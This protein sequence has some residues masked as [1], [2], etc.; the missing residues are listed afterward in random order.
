MAGIRYEFESTLFPWAARRELW[1]FARLPHDVSA[2]IHDAPH[3]P[4]GFNSVKVV[5]TLG[6][7]RWSTS[8]FPEGDG[9]FVLA[10]KKSI[11]LRE[12]VDLGDTVRMAVETML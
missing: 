9:T 3:P 12:G 5:A 11:R 10:I 6:S 4:A 7:S 1:V 8:I 2:E